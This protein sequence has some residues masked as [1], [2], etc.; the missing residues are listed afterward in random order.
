MKNVRLTNENDRL[1]KLAA[2]AENKTL[3]AI[4]NEILHKVLNPK[5]GH[6]KI[7]GEKNGRKKRPNL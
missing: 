7:G 2:I 1:L 3:Q 5:Y 4:V 6:I